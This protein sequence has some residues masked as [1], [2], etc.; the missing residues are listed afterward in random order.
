MDTFIIGF[1]AAGPVCYMLWRW[2][3][4]SHK[5][6]NRRNLLMAVLFI[7]IVAYLWWRG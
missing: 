2:M 3:D 6:A 4:P 7:G 1:I 5:H